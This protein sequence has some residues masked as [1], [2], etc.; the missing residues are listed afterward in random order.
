MKQRAIDHMNSD[1]LG[2]VIEFCKKFSGVAEP[3]N[4][5]MTDINED[6]M[7]ITCDEAVTFVPF[8]NKAGGDGFRDAIIELY[9]AIKDDT[10]VNTV[11]DGMDKFLNSFKTVLISSVRDDKPV[12]SYAP[13]IKD[14]SAYYICISSVAEHYHSLKQNPDKVSIMFIEDEKSAKSLFARVRVSFS[15]TAE[16]LD[17]SLKDEFMAK[18]EAAYPNESALAFIKDMKDFY[19]VKIT[20]IKGRYVKGFG[21]AYDTQGFKIVDSGRVNNPHTK[22]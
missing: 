15:A 12:S 7:E 1:H 2:I 18:F 4:V 9:T 14:E 11:Q 21:A 3:T 20:P 10:K 19:I 13:F 8:L 5:R 17:E 22:R 6:G 16:F